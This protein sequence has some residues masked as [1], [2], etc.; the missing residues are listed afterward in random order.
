MC[1]DANIYLYL[2]L[3]G[4]NRHHGGAEL[5]TVQRTKMRL[6]V[7]YSLHALHVLRN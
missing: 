2:G 5:T 6:A 1:R 4:K 3:W 7:I